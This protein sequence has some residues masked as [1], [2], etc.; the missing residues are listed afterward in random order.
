MPRLQAL[1][2]TSE[3]SLPTRV[4]ALPWAAIEASLDAQGYATTG[5]LLSA[6]GL[7]PRTSPRCRAEP[8][9]STYNAP[10]RWRSTLAS[11]A[12]SQETDPDAQTLSAERRGA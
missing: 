10:D 7:G 11:W 6:A 8:R 5:P 3:P 2:E 1:A 4:A 9:P 12:A